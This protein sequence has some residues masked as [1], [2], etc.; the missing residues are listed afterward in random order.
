MKFLVDENG[1]KGSVLLP[2]KAYREPMDDLADVAEIAERK[3][4]HSASLDSVKKR[5][6]RKWQ[7][8]ASK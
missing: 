5:L 4:Q 2:F 7:N 8:T 3:D 6:E 1:Q